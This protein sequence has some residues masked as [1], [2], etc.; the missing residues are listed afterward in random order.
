MSR[1]TSDPPA[2]DAAPGG[3]RSADRALAILG[4]FSAPGQQKAVGEIGRELGVHKSTA[5]RLVATLVAAGF[6][7][8]SGVGERVTLGP[9][10]VRLGRLAVSSRALPDLAAPDMDALAASAGET[11]T[12]SVADDGRTLTIAQRAGSHAVGLQNWVGKRSPLH[13]TSDG[14]VLLAFGAA[15][16][17][18]GALEP[19]TPETIIDRGVLAAALDAIRER[20][21]AGAEGEFE[22]GLN[23][24]AVPIL[25]ADGACRAALCVSGP[26]YRV[27]ATDFDAIGERCIA[28]AGRIAALLDLDPSPHP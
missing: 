12:L 8:R 25:A 19:R 14:K 6:L 15:D 16:L 28:A 26:A 22:L 4:A 27:R 7:E 10:L 9:E 21:W 17:P 20:G 18:G 23:G 11:V 13:A 3:V 1:I 2:D 5:S 24:V